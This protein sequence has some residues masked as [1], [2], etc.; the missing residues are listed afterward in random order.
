MRK[1]NFN[2]LCSF[3]MVMLLCIFT[4]AGS[5]DVQAKGFAPKVFA[6]KLVVIDPGCQSI[7]NN[8]KESVGPGAWSWETE[9]LVGAKGVNS[10][11]PEYDLNLTIAKKTEAALKKLGYK[12]E[13]TRTTNDVDMNNAERSMIANTMD[14]DLYLSIHASG[15]NKKDSGIFVL[16]ESADNP[17]NYGTYSQCRLLADVLRGCLQEKNLDSKDVIETD[18][19][20]GINWCQVPNAVVRVGNLKNSDDE[21]KLEDSE[22]QD[23]VAEGIAAGI[24]S[25]FAQK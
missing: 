18:D 15:E 14:A 7:E 23:K 10:E 22:Y 25:Y 12:V 13:L 1:K 9:D 8:K 16:C 5:I 21:E 17:Y 24:D 19:L 11:T 3:V 2:L 6:S 20:I 4:G